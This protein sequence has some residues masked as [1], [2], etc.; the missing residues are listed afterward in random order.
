MVTEADARVLEY[1]T[2]IVLVTGGHIT[3]L[4]HDTLKAR[5]IS[6]VREGADPDAASLAPPAHIRSVAIA[7]D[8]SGVAL[9][10]ALVPINTNRS[11]PSSS[12][13][14]RTP[15]S[16]RNTVSASSKVTRCF[17]W[18]SRFFASSHSKRSTATV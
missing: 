15:Q 16:S 1:G 6:V 12:S 13:L 4:A 8:H 18:F 3:P 17:R 2:T 7:G 5:R 11:S 9:K 14:I 10:A